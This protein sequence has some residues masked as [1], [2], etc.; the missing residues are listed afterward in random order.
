ML[1]HIIINLITLSPLL[2]LKFPFPFQT[3]YYWPSQNH[4]ADS[5]DYAIY[6]TKRLSRNKQK[7]GLEDYELEAYNKLKKTLSHKWDF[8][9]MQAD[10]QVGCGVRLRWLEVLLFD[11]FVEAPSWKTGE[12][13]G[14]QYFF[15]YE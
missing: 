11:E 1:S 6:L 14:E 3:P 4:S 15:C 12:G 13:Q 10:E 9:T 2:Q 7:H 8:I 5:T